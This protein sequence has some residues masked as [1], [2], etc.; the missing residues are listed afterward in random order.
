MPAF[1]DRLELMTAQDR[2]ADF[3]LWDYQPV[4]PPEN[5]FRS[6]NL[7]FHSFKI[8]GA[9]D[10][11]FDICQAIRDAIGPLCTVWGVKKMGDAIS[12]EFY[13][14]DYRGSQRE[15][16]ISKVLDAVRPYI[17]CRL[18]DSGHWPYFM[19]SFDLDK[20]L[21]DGDRALDEINV[22]IGNVGSNVSAGICYALTARGLS[23][24]NFYYFFDTERE[25]EEIVK[26]AACSVHCDVANHGIEAILWPDMTSC[27]TIVVANKK[28]R[29]GVYFSRISIEQLL[30]FLE[31]LEYPEDLVDFVRANKA[32][33]DHLLFDVGFDYVMRDGELRIVKSCYYGLF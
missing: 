32:S 19:F 5:K 6:S 11:A 26:K 8:A 17:D 14:Y 20:A 25:M 15:R 27:K 31:R 13:F 4:A 7:L 9:D 23:L 10:R 22:Y 29:D 2:L 30:I 33:L 24:E 3:C 18:T 28:E 21:I 16:S 12:W 1:E